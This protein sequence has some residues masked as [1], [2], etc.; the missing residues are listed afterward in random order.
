MILCTNIVFGIGPLIGSPEEIM[1]WVSEI[2]IYFL[3]L[4]KM[5]GKGD[6]NKI[7]LGKEV[8]DCY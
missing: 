7:L 5:V 1:G 8:C 6:G 2:K 3:I 4:E